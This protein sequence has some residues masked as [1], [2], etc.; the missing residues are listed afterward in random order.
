ML[1][2]NVKSTD[3]QITCPR[4]VALNY[5]NKE[6]LHVQEGGEGEGERE[7]ERERALEDK[8][9]ERLRIYVS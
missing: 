8:E 4:K 3:Y 5:Q 9:I 7:R 2:G 6:R 1:D